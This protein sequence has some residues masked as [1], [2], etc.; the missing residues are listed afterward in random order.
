MGIAQE[1]GIPEHS[2]LGSVLV[3]VMLYAEIHR[4]IFA[5]TVLLGIL[6]VLAE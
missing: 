6:G 3:K 2:G 4:R 5:E 1:L